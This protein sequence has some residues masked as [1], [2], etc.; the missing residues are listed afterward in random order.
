MKFFIKN[1]EKNNIK[2]VITK[3]NGQ[4]V[5]CYKNKQIKLEIIVNIC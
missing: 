1:N 3:I 5:A 2:H 4:L